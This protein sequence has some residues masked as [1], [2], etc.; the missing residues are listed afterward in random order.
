MTKVV[1]VLLIKPRAA[2]F[3]H[4]LSEISDTIY[5]FSVINGHK[6][7][8]SELEIITALVLESVPFTQGELITLKVQRWWL[9]RFGVGWGKEGRGF[10]S[11]LPML[12][13]PQTVLSNVP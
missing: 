1:P 7:C 2:V 3:N 4:G 12:L 13:L 5:F 11:S 10:A 6:L 9:S 8:T